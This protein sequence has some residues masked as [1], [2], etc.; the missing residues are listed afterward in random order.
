MCLLWRVLLSLV[1]RAHTAWQHTPPRPL[2]PCFVILGGLETDEGTSTL[3][4]G[5]HAV[6]R[7]LVDA[8]TEK[9]QENDGR[10]SFLAGILFYAPPSDDVPFALCSMADRST[11]MIFLRR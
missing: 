6:L 10:W 11:D 8:S 1:S 9:P 3:A 4:F 2:L 7:V 5:L